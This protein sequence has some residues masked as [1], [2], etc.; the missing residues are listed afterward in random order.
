MPIQ[1][2]MFVELHHFGSIEGRQ[3]R[4]GQGK[5]F[6]EEVVLDFVEMLPMPLIFFLTVLF[7]R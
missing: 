6:F 1:V 5:G 7:H 2:L 4:S 3:G